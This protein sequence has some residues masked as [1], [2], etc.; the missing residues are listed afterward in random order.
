MSAR[1]IEKALITAWN[2]FNA[3]AISTA[4]ENA[5]FAPVEGTPWAQVFFLPEQPKVATL[6]G[7]GEDEHLGIFQINL[8]YPQGAG[9]GAAA[10][11]ADAIREYF[12]A[13]ARFAFDSQDVLVLSSGRASGR[14]S[15]G[16]YIL[17]VEINF[18]ARTARSIS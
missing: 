11:K 18:M 12:E 15:Q 8:N 13:G 2:A 7:I 16:W 3:G 4:Y 1:K 17:P 6:S 5:N 10:D 9:A 14:N